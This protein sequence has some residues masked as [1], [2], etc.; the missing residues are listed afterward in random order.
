MTDYLVKGARGGQH[1]RQLPEF[2]TQL[3]I[4]EGL[5]KINVFYEKL[6]GF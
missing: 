3:S 5:S 4:I 2:L 6:F 1:L